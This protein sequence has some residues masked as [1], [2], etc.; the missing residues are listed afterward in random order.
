M[1]AIV[2]KAL[3]N[4]RSHRLSA[5]S[6]WLVLLAGCLLG[7]TAQAGSVENMAG[8]WSSLTLSGSLRAISPK[9]HQFRW[10]LINQTR[11]RDDNPAAWRLNEDQFYAQMGFTVNSYAS[12]WL[13][14]VHD[15]HH[16]LGKT[17]Y[18]ESRTYQDL[19]FDVPIT[20]F[21][22]KIRT[23]LEQ[24]VNQ[25]TGNM[26]IRLRQMATLQ[27]PLVF[28]D[29]KLSLYASDEVLCHL[30]ANSFGATGF[31]ENR[32]MAGFSFQFN[33]R[34]GVDLGYLGQTIQ[35]AGGDIVLTHNVNANLS[36]RF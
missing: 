13:G 14:Y 15:W 35:E 8:N 34:L 2:S 29:P 19:L 31:S 18:H 5:R 36:Y 7:T 9:F 28:I 10:I 27:F 21:K 16:S 22:A 26:G 1:S 6:A 23:R 20:P 30:N 11:L 12:V 33:R 17:A 4:L 25:T 3:N 24:R 32:A